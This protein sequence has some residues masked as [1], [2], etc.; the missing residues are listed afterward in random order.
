MKVVVP[1]PVA[2]QQSA[3]MPDGVELVPWIDGDPPDDALD[4]PFMMAPYSAGRPGRLARFT[5]LQVLLS[6]S[7]G[8]DW[9]ISQVPDGVVLCDASGVH[10]RSTSEWVLT[11]ILASIREIPRF[12]RQQ[13]E[14][15]W[16]SKDT[17]ELAGRRVLIVGYGSIGSAIE[18]RLAGFEVE[19]TKVAR[20]ARAGVHSIDEL[21]ELLPYA[22]VVVV[23]VPL[24]DETR[25]LVDAG[26]LARLP[27]G[28]LLVN[29]SR[30]PVVDAGALLAELH[31]GRITAA[32]DVTEEEPLPADN[33]LWSAPGLLLTPHVGG[34]TTNYRGRLHSL[35]RDQVVRHLAGEPLVNVV[36]DGY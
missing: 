19:I 29:A 32:V 36:Q 34:D 21:P 15:L 1:W 14:H 3:P 22:D 27:D 17:T 16:Q 18:R 6:Q 26:F 23:I 7:A 20:R 4:A 2:D 28:A 8:V 30:G 11:A 25:G 12:V 9:V 24:T 35:V 33:P 10:D 31:S 13:D 5:G